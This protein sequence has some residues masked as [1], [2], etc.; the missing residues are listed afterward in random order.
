MLNDYHSQ[1]FLIYLKCRDCGWR[2]PFLK[3]RY[4]HGLSTLN[5]EMYDTV[6][7]VCGHIMIQLKN[8]F[9]NY[10]YRRKLRR[11]SVKV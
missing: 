2:M 1:F 8:G 4:K 10:D 3:K 6:C 7:P 5:V 11:R 9:K